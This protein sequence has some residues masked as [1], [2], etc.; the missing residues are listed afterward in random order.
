[1][2]VTSF[3]FTPLVEFVWPP[4]PVKVQA[5]APKRKPKPKSKCRPARRVIPVQV[6]TIIIDRIEG[7]L[8][9]KSGRIRFNAESMPCEFLEF[10]LE[11]Y[12]LLMRI[13]MAEE[14]E[15]AKR[16]SRKATA[17]APASAGR[18]QVYAERRT[19]GCALYHPKDVGAVRKDG[20]QL[21]VTERKNG[22]GRRVVGWADEEG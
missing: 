18:I 10:T 3:V 4:K 14:Y 16:K 2:P 8:Q 12:E 9:A 5:P 21:V 22:T 19:A 11:E 7:E 15:P 1:M 17:S 13:I 20:V 6:R